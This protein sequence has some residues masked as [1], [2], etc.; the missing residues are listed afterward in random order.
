MPHRGQVED[1]HNIHHN[2]NHYKFDP[3]MTQCCVPNGCPI[4]QPIHMT[5]LSEAI[6]VI[7]NNDQC[8]EGKYM[9]RSCFESWEETVLTF[10]RSSG[11]ARS[12]SEKQRLQNLW[13]KKGY[14]LAY[15]ACGCKCGKGHLRKDLDWTPPVTSVNDDEAN[16]QK[17]KK[18]K[19]KRGSDKP[20][21]N[22]SGVNPTGMYYHFNIIEYN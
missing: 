14:D 19:K 15:K 5:N 16:S 2:N 4:G 11:R 13:T 21:V 22:V 20:T 7:C 10:L 12:W 9:H 3:S 1:C 6:K 17:K 18:N 8:K